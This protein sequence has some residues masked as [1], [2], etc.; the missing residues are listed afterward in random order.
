MLLGVLFALMWWAKPKEESLPASNVPK[1]SILTVSEL[2]HD[3]G[4]ISMKD[5]KVA[6]TFQVLNSGSAPLTIE[7]IITSCMCT[8]AFLDS[9]SGRKGPFGMPGHN[10]VPKVNEN[11]APGESR[12]IE[13]V[14]D[15]AAHGP[16]GVGPI[17]RNVFITDKD[18]GEVELTIKA[19]VIP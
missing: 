2:T 7:K 12:S 6:K 11:V 8:A 3:F 16:A 13:V 14:F 10:V 1:E 15:P 9:Q 17:T 19:V 5:G 18:G 4:K